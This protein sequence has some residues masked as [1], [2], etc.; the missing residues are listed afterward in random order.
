M[1]QC[2][3]V[4][5]ASAVRP[6]RAN[7]VPGM[8]VTAADA[9]QA[10]AGYFPSG[11]IG[12]PG[13]A[14]VLAVAREF[15]VPAAFGFE[16]RLGAAAAAA[17]FFLAYTRGQEESRVLAGLHPRIDLSGRLRSHPAWQGPRTLLREWLAQ[18][19][20]PWETVRSMTFEFDTSAGFPGG[21]APSVFFSMQGVADRLGVVRALA[22][23]SGAERISLGGLERVFRL[24]IAA[25][26]LF[27]V[28]AMLARP[29]AGLRLCFALDHP[30]TVTEFL[31]GIGW[32]G[33]LAGV[34]S[35][36]K[37]VAAWGTPMA[38]D[39]DVGAEIG[40]RVGIECFVP[41]ASLEG[42]SSAWRGLLDRLAAAGL[43]LPRERDALQGWFGGHRATLLWLRTY[44][45]RP[46]HVKLVYQ[47]GRP[48]HAKA[49]VGVW[50]AASCTAQG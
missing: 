23:G 49:Y 38:L 11:L 42:T 40:P 21:C 27:Q 5:G 46:S 39:I 14:R 20:G 6:L 43:C 31:S 36:L 33:S 7:A 4:T 19:N 12:P 22:A 2:D 13:L 10:A 17:D 41:V 30:E 1:P 45:R 3:D 47:D 25:E 32:R 9:V 37:R 16:L 28:G 35:L 29:S 34:G 8:P 24:P 18:E 15:P 26:R 44:V 48:L 50:E